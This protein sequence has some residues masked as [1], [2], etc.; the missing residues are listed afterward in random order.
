MSICRKGDGKRVA[1]AP[2]CMV[3]ADGE[4]MISAPFRRSERAPSGKRRS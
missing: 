3:K 1:D 2:V 4:A